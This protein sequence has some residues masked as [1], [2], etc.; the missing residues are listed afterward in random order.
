MAVFDAAL[1]TTRRMRLGDGPIAFARPGRSDTPRPGRVPHNKGQRYPADPP[2]VDEIVAVM[3]QPSRVRVQALI[4]VLWRA[5]LRV[6][7]ALALLETDLDE[8]CGS[9]LVRHGKGGSRREIGMMPGGRTAWS[10]AGRPGRAPRRPA[11][12]PAP[13]RSRQ[14]RDNL[15]LPARHRHRRDHRRRP[16]PA[17]TDDV[18]HRRTPTLIS[19]RERRDTPPPTPRHTCCSSSDP[20]VFA[21]NARAGT[22]TPA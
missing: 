14:P 11:A 19:W 15:D 5:G 12:H 20:Q 13:A 9:V 17:R 22:A 2:A 6:H 3:R 18:R 7:E 1:R 16:Q 10:L 21:L 8:R 4:V